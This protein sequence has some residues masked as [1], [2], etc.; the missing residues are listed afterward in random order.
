[1]ILSLISFLLNPGANI[2]CS[3]RKCLLYPVLLGGLWPLALQK[4]FRGLWTVLI[5]ILK[6]RD[7]TAQGESQIKQ[8]NRGF[9]SAQ[10]SVLPP[11]PKDQ[12]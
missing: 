6:I 11:L 9:F 7:V 8:L 5:T 2:S 1:M 3:L 10:T 12:L 4:E